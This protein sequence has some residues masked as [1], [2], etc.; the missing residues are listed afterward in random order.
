[1]KTNMRTNGIFNMLSLTLL[2]LAFAS[3]KK[4][5]T[6]GTA[7][8]TTTD[9]VSTSAVESTQAI[10]VAASRGT[11]G[12]SVY[13]VGTCARDHHR[14]SLAFSSLPSV[15]TDY[16]TANYAG[17][18]FQKAFTDKDTSG[19]IAGYIVIIQYNGNPVGL[20]FDAAGTFL[21]V[22]EQREGHDLNGPGWHH[23]GRF[24]DRDGMHKDTIAL[25]ALPAGV[26]NY[27][28][29]NYPEDT[30]VKAY[31]NKD[32]SIIVLSK[33][34]GAFATEFDVSGNFIKRVEL[35]ARPGHPTSITLADLPS[36]A[37]SYLTTTYPGY[38]F[39]QAF[40]ITQS[41]TVQGYAVFIEANS[42]SYAIAFD[43]S[44]NFLEAITIR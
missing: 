3:C 28:A 27:F 24:D 22:L 29:T 1:M 10:A 35:P 8:S 37:Q 5:Y 18:T 26:T 11:A 13:V 25:N 21:K 23:G 30:L 19:N 14:D 17:Y 20:K 2:L 34:S 15:I 9:S 44:G 4:D 7:T 36:A 38:V 31:K 12:D 16:L 40:E 6:A 32:G 39:K 42:T 41:G 43:A 33:N